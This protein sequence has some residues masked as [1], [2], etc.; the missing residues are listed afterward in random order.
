[1]RLLDKSALHHLDAGSRKLCFGLFLREGRHR[2]IFIEHG[3]PR[4]VLLEVLAHEFAHA[5]QSEQSPP[6]APL[7]VQE[8]FAE[9]VSYKLLESLGCHKRM[10]RI[11]KRDDLYGQG[12]QQVLAWERESGVAGVL[13]KVK[14]IF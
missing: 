10:A 4:I 1:M 7:E 14:N 12:L 11:L 6:D 2:A 8:G 9:W 5:W 13:A 3:L